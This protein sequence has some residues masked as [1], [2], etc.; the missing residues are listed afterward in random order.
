MMLKALGIL[1]DNWLEGTQC[2][3]FKT[4]LDKETYPVL[5]NLI[6]NLASQLRF[7]LPDKLFLRPSQT[8]NFKDTGQRIMLDF[9]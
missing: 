2:R 5:H 9:D 7:S 8:R 6:D 3:V 4:T 1:G